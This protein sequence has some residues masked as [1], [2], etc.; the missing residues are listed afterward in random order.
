[1]ACLY[2][3]TDCLFIANSAK[4][5][6]GKKAGTV[7][8]NNMNKFEYDFLIKKVSGVKAQSNVIAHR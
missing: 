1:M 2:A 6:S 8:I 3:V 4:D 5:Y 7:G